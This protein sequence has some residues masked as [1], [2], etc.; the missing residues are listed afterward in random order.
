[1][2]KKQRILKLKPTQFAVGMLEVDEKIKEVKKYSKKQIK[3]YVHDHVVPVVRSPEN[4]LYI[5]DRHHFLS[6]CL[7]LGIEKVFVEVIKDFHKTEMSYVEF[8]DWMR[9]SRNSYP[10][11]QFGEGPRN[12]IYL[13][14]DIRGLGDDPYRS[15]A[16][17][18]RKA[19]GFENTEKY[20]AEFQWANFFR[21]KK[22][23][24]SEG[25]KGLPAALKEAVRL[26]QTPEAEKLPGYI[27]HDRK[28][29][30]EIKEE[31]VD[32]GEK[33]DKSLREL[34]KPD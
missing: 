27:K 30:E 17:F 5:V 4:E 21:S 3:K 14:N 22:L 10:Y 2:K 33:V 25:R 32:K 28:E 8:W 29:I 34:G 31:I 20:F 6:V 12:A 19:G 7:H 13:P 9:E 11:C 15:I 18:V 23:L 1:M 26:A 16:W 24:D